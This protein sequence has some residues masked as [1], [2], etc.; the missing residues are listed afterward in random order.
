ME[1][2]AVPIYAVA[3]CT[4]LRMG[5]PTPPRDPD[6]AWLGGDL[7]FDDDERPQCPWCKNFVEVGQP[8]FRYK[9]ILWHAGCWEDH[10]TIESKEVPA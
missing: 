5:P 4:P 10:E 9:G 7:S 1:E 3:R 2:R 6:L 8:T